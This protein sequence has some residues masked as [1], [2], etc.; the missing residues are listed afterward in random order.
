MPK[1]INNLQFEEEL[2]HIPS[3]NEPVLQ[4]EDL[5]IKT[6][7]ISRAEIRSAIERL[8]WKPDWDG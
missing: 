3:L 2:I 4:P 7:N 5:L 8:D 1:L 6:H